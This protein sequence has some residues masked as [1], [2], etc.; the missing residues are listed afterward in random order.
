MTFNIVLAYY[1]NRIFRQ[2]KSAVQKK[3]SHNEPSVVLPST[4]VR[5][6]SPVVLI[7]TRGESNYSMI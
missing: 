1:R 7:F 3:V 4:V 5:L 6:G 2:Q